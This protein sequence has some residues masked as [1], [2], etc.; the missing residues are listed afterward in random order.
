[1]VILGGGAAG[2]GIARLLRIALARQGRSRRG[3]L[4]IHRRRR[5]PRAAGRRQP[6]A[7]A[8]KRPFAWPAALAARRGLAG[9]RRASAA[10]DR[11]CEPTVLIGAS[12]RAGTFNEAVI[13]SMARHVERPVVLPLS[14]PT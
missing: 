12:G 2:I 5:Q 9:G 13:R 14:N 10:R 7:D 1:M 3:A 8:H 4:R 6:I 11:A